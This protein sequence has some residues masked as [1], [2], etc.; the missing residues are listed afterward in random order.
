VLAANL[1]LRVHMRVFRAHR[2]PC[3]DFRGEIGTKY[4]S[5][6]TLLCPQRNLGPARGT[7]FNL[8]KNHSPYFHFPPSGILERG[9]LVSFFPTT[10]TIV[11]LISASV[12]RHRRGKYTPKLA[13]FQ[14][15]PAIFQSLPF[16]RLFEDFFCEF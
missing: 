5:Q 4:A 11:N 8:S 12:R 3:L 7:P 2:R 9:T 16:A 10:F 14:I 15:N 13:T 1:R 6:V